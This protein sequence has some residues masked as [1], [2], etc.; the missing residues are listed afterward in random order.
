M[1]GHNR[2]QFNIVTII[3]ECKQT[4]DELEAQMQAVQRARTSM[5]AITVGET[6]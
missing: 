1:E 2:P 4:R 3:G 6:A 5:A